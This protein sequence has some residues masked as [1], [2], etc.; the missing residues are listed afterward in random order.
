MASPIQQLR[1]HEAF[2][3]MVRGEH[4]IVIGIWAWFVLSW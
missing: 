4:S 1:Q 2:R 3:R